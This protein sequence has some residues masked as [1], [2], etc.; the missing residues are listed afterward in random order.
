M[1]RAW[2]FIHKSLSDNEISELAA[3]DI[4]G[5]SVLYGLGAKAGIKLR[6]IAEILG[7]T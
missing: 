6:K 4:Y 7:T 1:P 2:V 3:A 5:S